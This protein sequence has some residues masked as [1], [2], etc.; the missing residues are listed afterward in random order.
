M[1]R[2]TE[3]L[4]ATELDQADAAILEAHARTQA[5]AAA[6]TQWEEVARIEALSLSQGAGVQHDFLRAE[7]SLFQ[8]RAALSRAR[9]DEVLAYVRSARAQGALNRAW[10]TAALEAGR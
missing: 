10:V 4:V 1:L 3:L 8:A 5:L 2:S 9:Y 7:A 6:V